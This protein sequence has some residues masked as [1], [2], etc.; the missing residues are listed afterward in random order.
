MRP[1]Y[2]DAY[3]INLDLLLGLFSKDHIIHLPLSPYSATYDSPSTLPTISIS[4]F[5]L[6]L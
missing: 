2:L 3:L 6:V 1:S 4:L 5:A